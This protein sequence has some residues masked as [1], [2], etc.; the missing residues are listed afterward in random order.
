MPALGY[1]TYA[2]T[3]GA[4]PVSGTPLRTAASLIE[5]DHIRLELDPASGRIAH[6]VLREDGRDLADLA[7]ASRPRTVVVNDTSDTWG[8]RQLAYRDELGAFETTSVE[9]VESGPVRAILR[10]NS[11][12]EDSVLTEDFIVS[13]NAETVELRVILDWRQKAELLKIRM[14]TALTDVVAAYEIPYGAIER[15]ADGEE[16]PGQRW[17][18]VSGTLPGT[19]GRFG[20][21]VLNDANTAS[22]SSTESSA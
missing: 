10:V 1:R 20:L 4:R 9:L 21:A 12:Y 2:M 5:N 14:P 22:T 6:L 18:D 3:A 15:P 13:A 11:R 17:I 7:D 8:H 16:E 19:P